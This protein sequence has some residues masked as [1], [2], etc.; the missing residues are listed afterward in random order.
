MRRVADCVPHLS[1][2]QMAGREQR[3]DQGGFCWSASSLQMHCVGLL[4]LAALVT[5]MFAPCF[6]GVTE[7]VM[8]TIL[9]ELSLDP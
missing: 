4:D 3:G 6:G 2:K 9:G 5:Q 7:G 1:H 8:E